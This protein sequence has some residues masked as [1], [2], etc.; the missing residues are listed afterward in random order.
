[1]AIQSVG[2]RVSACSIDFNNDSVSACKNGTLSADTFATIMTV[3]VMPS[4]SY[5]SA[6]YL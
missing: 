6:K 2:K 4:S 1:M 3:V 5:L